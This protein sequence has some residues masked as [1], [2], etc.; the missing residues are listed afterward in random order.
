[1]NRR[2]KLSIMLL[3]FALGAF[4]IWLFVSNG[5]PEVLKPVNVNTASFA[6]LDAIPWLTPDSAR[7]IIAGRPFSSV[8][9]LLTVRGIG[10][11]T[12]EKIRE[13]VK[14]EE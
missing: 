3:I 10:D 12:L 11:K 9:E 6:E 7:G 4:A 2:T 1:M 8:N 14:V 13:F 5:K